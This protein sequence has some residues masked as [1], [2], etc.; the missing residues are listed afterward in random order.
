MRLR[1]NSDVIPK[2]LWH[3]W[4]KVSVAFDPGFPHPTCTAFSAGLVDSNVN[5]LFG[6]DLDFDIFRCYIIQSNIFLNVCPSW[7]L[8]LEFMFSYC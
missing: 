2:V 5:S 4:E 3:S 7:V 8:I 6:L 1:S